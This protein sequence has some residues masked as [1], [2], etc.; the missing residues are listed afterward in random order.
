MSIDI[1][2]I[3]QLLNIAPISV[4]VYV[5][6][7]THGELNLKNLVSF[8][9]DTKKEVEQGLA[10]LMD[11]GF[12]DLVEL[13]DGLEAYRVNSVFQMEEALERQGDAIKKLKKFVIPKVKPP[14]KLGIMK[15]EGFEGIKKVYMEVLEE[16]S[17]SG[18]DILA[19]ESS[20]DVK[21][22]GSAFIDNYITKR[23]KNKVKAYVI[24]PGEESDKEYKEQLEGNF[25]F[26][27]MLP[28]FD[29]KANIN[30]VGDL[31]MAFSLSEP[32]QGTLRRNLEEAETLKSIFWKL[33]DLKN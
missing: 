31:V 11:K 15:Y 26:I 23:I 30:I 4:K 3:S 18:E 29:I 28:K 9:D 16:A 1:Q 20:K 17:R 2:E 8:M 5:E 19:F 27:K 21:V 24:T 6:L 13:E 32:Y 10:E 12:V 22:L 33:W 14:K 25:T 7:L